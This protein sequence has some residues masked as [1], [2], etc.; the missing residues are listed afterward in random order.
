MILV[1]DNYDS[2]TFNLVQALEAAGRRG[3]G[4]PQRRDRPGRP[5]RPW[6]TDAGRRDLTRASSSRPVRATPTTPASRS[7]SI[8]VAAERGIPLLGVCLGISRWPRPSARA[9]VRAPTLV[10]GEAA[11]VTHDGAGPARRACRRVHGDPLPLAVRRSRRRLP[12]ELRGHRD[13]R[14]DGVVMGMRHVDAAAS[15]ASSSTPRAC[16]RPRGRTCSRTSC[17]SPGRA[18]RRGS[19]TGRGSLRDRSG[20]RP[21]AR[22]ES[23]PMS[24]HGPG[25][26]GRGRRGRDAR[27]EDGARRDG[28][29]HGRRG[30]AGPARGA[31]HRPADARRDGRRAGRL[32]D[33]D[34]RARAPRSRRPRA[35][36]TSSAPAATARARST[37]RRRPAFVVAAAGVPVAKHGNRAITSRSGSADVLEALGVRIDHDAESAAAD[38]RARSASPS[39]S[40][41]AS[42]RRCATPARPAA[43]SASG[44]R[45]TSSAR[46]RTRPARRRGARRRGRRRRRRRGWPRSLGAL[47]TERT[48][49]VHGDGHR[50]AAARRH[51]AC[52]YDVT[53]RRGRASRGRR[54]ARSGSA[55]RRRRRSPAARRPRTRRSSRRSSTARRARGATS[56]CS[57]PVRRSWP[58]AAS[59]SLRRGGRAG[60]RDDRRGPRGASSWPGC[61]PR[62]RAADAAPRSRGRRAARRDDRARGRRAARRRRPRSP[63]VGR[64]DVARRARRRS[65]DRAPPRRR[66]PRRRRARSPSGSRRPA[67]TSS[68]RSSAR[69]PSAGRDRRRAATTSSPAPAPTRR[70]GAAAISVLC[71]PHWFGGSVDDLARGPGGGHACRSWPRSSSSTRA[72][73]RAPARRR[74]GPRPPARGRS[75]ARRAPRAAR[76]ARPDLGLEPLVEA[77]DERELEAALATRARLIGLNNRDLRTLA[78]DPER[79][80]RAA[81]ARARRPPR[82]RR[83]RR[84]RAG[85][86]A[87]LAGGRASTPRSSARRSSAP[88]DPEAAARAFVAA[89]RPPADPANARPGPV[90][91]DLRRHRRGRRRAAV[92]AGA[93][94]IGLN[95]VPGT[96]RALDARRGGRPRRAPRGP[97]P[98]PGRGR[99]SSPITVDR[100]ADELEPDRRGPRP[101]RD[102]AERRRAAVAHR[103][104]STRPAWKVLH[105]PA[106]ADGRTA[107]R[108]PT[109]SSRNRARGPGGTRRRRRADPARHG[110]RPA[111][112]RHGRSAP[113]PASPPPSPARCR[114]TLAGGL[115]PANVGP[116]LRGRADVGV[117]VASGVEAP[118]DARAS[119]RARTRCRSRSS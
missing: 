74:R 1:I 89:G 79:A 90:R 44:P 61:G 28:R 100:P 82:R 23:A 59:P 78:V 108:R 56:C 6:P 112:R 118:R 57:T 30:D 71:E 49:V 36:S 19:T 119:G 72:S 16:S 8:E 39:C 4:A 26:P 75:T 110:R 69:S 64:A 84:P 116:A 114:S 40:R 53:P 55:A 68:P 20:L 66:R 96:P 35:R 14:G 12:A 7:T 22:P 32:R 83:V 47:G 81:R 21:S 85:D 88:A 91:E 70:G 105:L 18:R 33:G 101:R 54:R 99:S 62:R 34:A 95:L 67:S 65:T 63:S 29:G 46:S 94:A 2:F 31:P 43:R 109:P 48:L 51:A 13:E 60:R 41:P 76:R 111:P 10:H 15:R 87:R 98:R 52:V 42:T 86:G 37:S 73:C 45:S 58:P 97:S 102:P 24:E 38:A 93:D 27:L 115:D 11:E 106:A 50:R 107:V 25:R 3:R 9:I 113:I 117:D 5:S 80:V 92:R 103:A 17:A 77:H 104:R